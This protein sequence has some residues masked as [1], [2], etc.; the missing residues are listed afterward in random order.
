MDN[1]KYLEN[2]CSNTHTYKSCQYDE[3]IK[4]DHTVSMKIHG[5]QHIILL[6]LLVYEEIITI[7]FLL[8]IK[9]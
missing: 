6:S 4:I 3:Y 8:E 7:S 5:I 2:Y 1:S 9:P